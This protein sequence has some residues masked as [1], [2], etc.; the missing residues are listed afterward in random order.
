MDLIA[1]FLVRGLNLVFHILPIHFNLW[2]GRRFGSVICVLSAK[3]RSVTYTNLKAAF[4]E[5]KPP[6]EI[7][8]LTKEVYSNLS[9]TFIEILSMTKANKRYIEKYVKV[10]NIERIEKASKNPKGMILL[11]AHFGNWELSTVTSVMKGFPLYLLARDQKMKRLNELLNKLR[12]LKGNIVIRKGADIKN[13]FR[14]LHNGKAVGILA[15]QNAGSQGELIELFNRP[16]STAVGP[17]RFAQKSGS[18]I[19]PAFIHR[20]KGPYHELVLEEPM[21]IKK[22]EDITPYLTEYN[23]LLE[24]H[25]RNYPGQWL[26]MHKKWKL[27]PVKKIMVL[28]DGKKGHLNQSL[29]AVKQI[30]R[31]RENK[32]FLPEET[33]VDTMRIEFKHK[34]AKVIFNF[35]S[36]VFTRRCQGC[37]KC[38]RRALTKDSYNE[39]I[40]KYAD[41][42]VSCGSSLFGVNK[43]MK[44]ENNARN[45]TIFDPGFLNKKAFDL[46]I[47]PRHDLKNRMFKTDRIIITELA[48]NLITPNNHDIRYTICDIRVIG[49]LF[50]GDNSCFKFSAELT[51][52]IARAVID[53][54]IRIGAHF[55]ATTSRRTP[56]IADKI[57]RDALKG[58]E[59]CVRFI[60][61]QCNTDERTVEKIL[62]ACDIVIVSGESISM[63]SEAVSSG[64]RVLVFMPDKKTTRYTKYERFVK[65]LDGKGYIKLVTPGQI[66]DEVEKAFTEAVRFIPKI[67][68]NER[69]YK[70]MYRLF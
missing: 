57:L 12:E 26:W 15:D 58:D 60:Q 9:E 52:T 33:S 66:P 64:K 44:I 36:P 46:I 25:I 17:Y 13:L 63:V 7:K 67:D 70:E 27:T 37:L 2:L 34:A 18:W 40:S 6:E 42:I 43:I 38:L 35:L 54:S 59:R 30:K 1:S 10:R 51:N 68:D 49:L 47:I 3:R 23:R 48:P 21:V 19:L 50:G 22:G 61:G 4:S 5:K 16:A 32:G 24:G 62:A 20:V 41:V 69:M 14:V 56:M 8:R 29:S 31:Y 65:S 55:Y 11:S 45:L 39:L 53:A 28:D